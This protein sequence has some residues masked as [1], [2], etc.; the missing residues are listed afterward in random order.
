M[1]SVNP[2]LLV[3]VLVVVFIKVSNPYRKYSTKDYWKLATIDSVNEISNEALAPGN[4]NGGVL[5]WA[6]MATKDPDILSALVQRGADINEADGIFKGTSL[7]GAAGYSSS[8]KIID[9]LIQLGVGA[10]ISQKVNNNEDAL[11]IAAQYNTI[12]IKE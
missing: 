2:K 7:T 4:K 1:S 11:M 12:Q 8:P 9:R 5:M 6:A 3:V 10:D